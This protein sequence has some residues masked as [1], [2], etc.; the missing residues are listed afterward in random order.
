MKHDPND[1]KVMFNHA[2]ELLVDT[3]PSVSRVILVYQRVS[4]QNAGHVGCFAKSI[5]FPDSWEVPFS[6]M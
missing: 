6:S 1:Q 3:D 4:N 5:E 2:S